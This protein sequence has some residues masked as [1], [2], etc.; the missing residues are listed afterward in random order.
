M[1]PAEESLAAAGDPVAITRQQVRTRPSQ[2][3]G[4]K[5]S[6]ETQA[7]NDTA[8]LAA[9]LAAEIR[10]HLR[11]LKAENSSGRPLKAGERQARREQ[12]RTLLQ[13]YRNAHDALQQSLAG[14]DARIARQGFGPVVRNRHRQALAA[15]EQGQ[16]KLSAAVGQV[17][18]GD[19][20]AIDQALAAVEQ[21]SGATEPDLTKAS[22]TLRVHVQ[23]APELTRE[24]ADALLARA[25]KAPAPAPSGAI[26]ASGPPPGAGDLAATIEVELT[27]EIAAQAAALGNSPLA[28]YEFVRNKVEFQPYLGSRKGAVE[29]LHQLRGN[30]TDQA[31]LLLALLR[32][33]GIPSRY[34]R[35]TVEMTPERA[36]SWLGVDDAHTAGSILTTAG[37]DGINIVNGP[38]VVAIR[39]TRVWVEAWLPY[40]N[41]RGVPREATGKVWIPL[42]PAFKLSDVTPGQDVLAA[43]GFNTQAF[44]DDYISTFH[45]LSPIEKFV[46]DIQTWLNTNQPGTTV[47]QIE[48]LIALK[49]EALGLVP[50]SLPYDVRATGSRFSELEDAKRYKVRFH[51]YNGGTNFINHTTNLSQIAGRRVTIDYVAAT[52]ADQAIIDSYGGIF[53]TPPSLVSLKPRLKLDGTPLATSANA[54]G[55]G[56]THSSDMQFYQPSGASNVQPLV[57]NTIIAGNTQAIGINTF[58]DA[59]DSALFGAPGASLLET[60]L[61]SNAM[62][63]L[64]R[65]DDG[66][67]KAGGLMRIVTT[68]DVSEAIVESQVRVAF[69]GG[70]PVSFAAAGLIVDADRRIVGTF[71]VDG[72][73]AK[74]IP[75]MLLTGYDG[76]IM[77]NRIF[78]DTYGQPAVSTIKILEL[79]NDAGI[80]TRRIVTS[81]AADAPDLNQPPEIVNAINAA[82]AQG[83]IVIIPRTGMTISDWTG[84]GYIDLDPTD[85]AAGYIISGGIS[86][87]VSS[88]GGATVVQTWSKALTCAATSVTCEVTKPPS[89][90]P[91]QG[92]V[93]CAKD[94]NKLKF[95]VMLHVTCRDGSMSDIPWNFETTA[96]IRAIADDPRF[97]PGDY[98]LTVSALGSQVCMRKLTI[99]KVEF[100]KD[101]DCAGFDETLNPPWVMVPKSGTNKVKCEITPASAA[102]AIAFES[103]DTGKATVSPAT[104]SASPETVT[105]SGV[106]KG[107]T[108]IRAKITGGTIVCAIVKASVKERL[109][110][111]IV[112]H[113]ITEQNDDVQAIAVGK[114][115]P[116]QVCITAGTNGALNTT[117]AGDDVVAG[118]SINTGPNGIC[119][120]AKAG[121][122]V[123]TIAVGNGKANTIAVTKGA[124]SFRDTKPSGDDVVNG[125]SV[126]T[127]LDG[128][129]NTAANATNLVPTNFPTPAGLQQYLNDSIWGLQAN[130]FC[131]VTESSSTLN[132]DLDRDGKLDDPYEGPPGTPKNPNDFSEV[133]VVRGAKDT[134][135]DIN[136]YYVKSYEYPIG[137]TVADEV[138]TVGKGD[139]SIVNH[140]AH[141]VGH[142]MGRA[143]ESNNVEDVMYKSGLMTDPCRVLKVDWDAVNP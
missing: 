30:D 79:A 40:S 118:T 57:Q 86:G 98:T 13:A 135:V 113:K 133:N 76:S 21:E 100:K 26:A 54:I 38:N 122:D 134:T 77:E 43:M 23:Q 69:S 120:T 22:P 32:S 110:K 95:E 121:D 42:D 27:P 11:A 130:V 115:Q 89:D 106:A 55:M 91:A 70:V 84:T 74:N 4:P 82:L 73:S 36:K 71:P 33:A 31:S 140:T 29:T 5:V 47:D 59:N 16:R 56:R 93:F 136:I 112:I 117:A 35:G 61:H 143:G 141:E 81:I 94:T 58:L 137:L 34:V 63:Y 65:V 90:S 92:A 138:F 78:E 142:A 108:D 52:P 2:V 124:N 132:Y 15:L 83:H 75:Y 72:N 8:A 24:E 80:P 9:G 85:G 7:R 48:R 99:V 18:A 25:P 46:A 102:S 131:T 68:Q 88:H 14:S 41:Y 60:L 107:T 104:A 87:G 111:K 139:N 10:S 44:L 103:A 3:G 53:E 109:N 101:Q 97:G 62:S 105:V 64:S 67:R 1:D 116:N 45:A 96:T 123:Q 128:I 129:A 126:D 66:E 50:A 28:I 39:C 119:N 6:A 114:G 12:L 125:D 20:A 51:L 37:M 17:A 19:D 49:S 127:G